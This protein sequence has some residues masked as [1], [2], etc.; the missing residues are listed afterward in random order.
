MEKVFVYPLIDAEKQICKRS[1]IMSQ[2]NT[3][4]QNCQ[5]FY[6][7]VRDIYLALITNQAKNTDIALAITLVRT[8]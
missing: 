5:D 6:S 1:K 2:A 4:Y 3:C 8:S 7:T